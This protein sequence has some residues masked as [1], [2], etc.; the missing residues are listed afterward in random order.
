MER[1]S[2]RL[3]L[4]FKESE[5]LFSNPITIPVTQEDD[6][7]GAVAKSCR[8]PH[9]ALH[10]I[11]ENGRDPARDETCFRH[12]NIAIRQDFHPTGMFEAC[13][14]RIHLEPGRGSRQMTRRPPFRGW[15]FE[16]W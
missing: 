14:K 2:K 6:A 8:A 5:P 15:H 3:V 10:G 1:H 16:G 4:V 13:G 7:I 11:V 9:R 12:G